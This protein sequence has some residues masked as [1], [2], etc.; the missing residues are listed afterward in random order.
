LRRG[1]V[2]TWPFELVSKQ[3]IVDLEVVKGTTVG[4]IAHLLD[5]SPER[6]TLPQRRLTPFTEVERADVEEAVVE[7]DVGRVWAIIDIAL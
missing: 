7:D 3:F 5:E 1:H 2:T 4:T 6:T